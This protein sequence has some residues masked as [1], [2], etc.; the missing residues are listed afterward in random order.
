MSTYVALN[1][2]PV[3]IILLFVCYEIWKATMEVWL[4]VLFVDKQI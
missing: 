1:T 4:Q 3:C 2:Y